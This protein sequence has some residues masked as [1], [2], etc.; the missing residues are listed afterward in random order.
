LLTAEIEL[1]EGRRSVAKIGRDAALRA[2]LLA[3]SETA[4]LWGRF[5]QARQKV[6]D[7]SWELS[8]VHIFLQPPFHWD[9]R[10]EDRDAGQG[11]AW[12]AA[13]SALETDADAAL[14]GE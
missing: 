14:P 10:L 9:G 11:D 13:I 8:A 4:A 5:Q 1:V 6:R 2:V 12:K 3:S 7:L